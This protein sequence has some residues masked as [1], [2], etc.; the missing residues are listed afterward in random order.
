[1]TE[2]QGWFTIGVLTAILSQLI[3]MNDYPFLAFAA[4]ACAFGLAILGLL[5]K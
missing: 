3:S 2:S 1:M 5:V 4:G